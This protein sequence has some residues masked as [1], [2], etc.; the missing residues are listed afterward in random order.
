MKKNVRLLLAFAVVLVLCLAC[1]GALAE[2]VDGL[3][4]EKKNGLLTVTAF[5]GSTTEVVV[6]EGVEAIGDYAFDNKTLIISVTLPSTLQSIG[7][8]AFY[9]CTLLET[10]IL[11]D[12]CTSIGERAFANSTKLEEII[13]PASV[14][15]IAENA[16][17]GCSGV[18]VIAP[19]GSTAQTFAQKTD[20][21]SWEEGM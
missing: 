9:D 19:Y 13:I 11:P 14:T 2:V 16:F 7:Q 1:A 20:G 6:P 5:D 18:K 17:E 21:L 3:T 8:Y 10:V 4:I 12:G 15:E